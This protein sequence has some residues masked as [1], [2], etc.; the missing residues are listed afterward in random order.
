[1]LDLVDT[2]G[3]G[4]VIFVMALLELIGIAWV[5]GLSNV[6]RDIEFMLNKKISLVSF[7]FIKLFILILLFNTIHFMLQYWKFCWGNIFYFRYDS[8]IL[9]NM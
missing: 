5:Y 9:F 3:A 7:R 4:F 1:M 8:H 2:F 6:I